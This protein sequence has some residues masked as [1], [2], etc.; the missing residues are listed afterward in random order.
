MVYAKKLFEIY[1]N[2]VVL[3]Q[4]YCNLHT[5][6]PR[7]LKLEGKDKKTRNIKNSNFQKISIRNLG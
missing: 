4:T 1:F 6:K 5:V 3:F 7:Y 2:V